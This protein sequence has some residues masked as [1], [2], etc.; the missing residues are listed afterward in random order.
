MVG[1]NTYNA[2][3]LDKI[4]VT[5]IAG[6]AFTKQGGAAHAWPNDGIVNLASALAQDV[7][8]AVIPHRRCH[9]YE[10]GTHSL[11]IS[12]H[13]D[14]QRPEAAAITWN[15]TVGEWIERAIR[16]ADVALWQPNREG[17]PKPE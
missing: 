2:G 7:P 11:W 10:G 12:A 8:D 6:N 15:G 16:E 3:V 17:C 4:P 14:P 13:A 9:L 1:L 5:L